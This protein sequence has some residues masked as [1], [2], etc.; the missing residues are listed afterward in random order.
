MTD[1]EVPPVS[2]MSA[3][4]A[5]AIRNGIIGVCILALVL[6]FQPFSR[7][8][9]SAGCVLVVFGG[10]AFN[11]VPLSEKGRPLRSLAVASAIVIAALFVIAGLAI[12]SAWLYG[13]YFVRQP[14]Q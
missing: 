5:N 14:G 1:L 7:A 9:F 13:L 10:L 11:L 2:G 4:T 3:R 12:F 8:L 6:I